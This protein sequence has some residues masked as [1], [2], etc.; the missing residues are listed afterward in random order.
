MRRITLM[1]TVMAV[2]LSACTLGNI[3]N[4]PALEEIS[5]LSEARAKVRNGMTMAQVQTAIGDPSSRAVQNNTTIWI[6]SARQQNIGGRE[7]LTSAVGAYVPS[8]NRMITVQFNGAGR[9]RDVSYN[10]VTL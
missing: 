1:S 2:A 8:N 9:V 10:E 4:N 6:Y 5:S 3:Y 7:I